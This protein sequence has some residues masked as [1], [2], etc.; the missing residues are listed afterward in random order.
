MKIAIITYIFLGFLTVY[1][2]EEIPERNDSRTTAEIMKANKISSKALCKTSCQSKF[3]RCYN[4]NKKAGLRCA[5]K[6]VSCQ[7]KCK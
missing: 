7:N 4:Q 3:S 1:G 2:N 6:A 5:A